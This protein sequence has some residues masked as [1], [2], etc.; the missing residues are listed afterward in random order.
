MRSSYQ[1]IVDALAEHEEASE[2]LSEAYKEAQGKPGQWKSTDEP[3]RARIDRT[4]AYAI[5]RESV[6][7]R[8]LSEACFRAGI[9]TGDMEP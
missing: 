7:K 9:R 6:S 5:A 1:I 4:V 2:R 8:L 3:G